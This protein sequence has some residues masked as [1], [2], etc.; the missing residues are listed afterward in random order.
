[1][2]LM[3]S[4]RYV[5][6]VTRRLPEE[7]RDDVGAELRASID[8]QVEAVLAETPTL[9]LAEAEHAALVQLGD[10][11]VLAASYAGRRLQLIGPTL[12]PAYV[13]LLKLVLATAVPA[14]AIT[15]AVIDAFAGESIGDIVG[16]AVGVAFEVGIQVAFWITVVFAIAER[17]SD[18]SVAASL[19]TEWTPER[20]PKLPQVRGSLGETITGVCFLALLGMLIVW[21]QVRPPV[22]TDDGNLPVLDPDLWS[23]WLPVV[24]V[25]IVAEMVFE[26]I[27][28]RLGG[29]TMRTAV[30]NLVMGAIFAA[31]MVY[32]AASERL[33][34]PAVVEAIQVQWAEFDAAGAHLAIVVVSLVIWVWDSVEGFWKAR[35]AQ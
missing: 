24:L 14:V 15:L 30:A 23:F 11:E 33:I 2:S 3:L 17:T 5:H 29:W 28:Y 1:M 35:A 19:R 4:E 26:V 31:P 13:A 18:E 34:N 8:D 16:G 22:R 27:K 20:L 12:Y 21:Q 25:V 7:Q 9:S 32:L 10:P 6:A